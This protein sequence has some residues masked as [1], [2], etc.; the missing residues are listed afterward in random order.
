ML[1]PTCQSFVGFAF[2]FTDRPLVFMM[3]FLVMK[4]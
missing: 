2:H 4:D 1:S 3:M